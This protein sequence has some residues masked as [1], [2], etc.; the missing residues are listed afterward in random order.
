MNQT[1]LKQSHSETSSSEPLIE[2]ARK[3]LPVISSEAAAGEAAGHLTEKTVAALRSQGLFGLLA[4]KCY[5]GLEAGA[6]EALEIFELI[7]QTDG[8]TGWVTMAAAV[9]TAVTAA[10]LPEAGAE[11]VFGKRLSITAGQGSPRGK[12]IP[13][14]NGYRVTGKWSYGSGV[15]HADYLHTGARVYENGVAREAMTCI[16]PVAQAKILGNWDVHRVASDRQRRLLARGCVR[17][18]GFYTFG[19]HTGATARERSL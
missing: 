4:P 12:A 16:V 13:D 6:V 7:S 3:I 14:G 1:S 5:G 18:K 19:R 9:T 11:A 17:A 8:S 15:L 10:F 2:R